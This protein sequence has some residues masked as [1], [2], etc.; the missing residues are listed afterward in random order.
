MD[1][2]SSQIEFQLSHRDTYHKEKMAELEER[3][4]Q[5]V[6]QERAKY[7]VLAQEKTDMDAEYEDHIQVLEDTHQKQL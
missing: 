4:G 1:E 2:L 3:Y 6:E 5:E 7:E